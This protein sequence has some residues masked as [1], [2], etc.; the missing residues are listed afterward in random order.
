M[1]RELLREMGLDH[2]RYGTSMWNPL[3]DWIRRGQSVFALVNFVTDRR[4]TQ[5]FVDFTAMVTHPSVI[6]PV[7]DYLIIAT[8]DATLVNFGNAPVQSARM[9]RLGRG[10]GADRL[11]EFSLRHV[12]RE[13]GPHDLRLYTSCVNALGFKTRSTGG[14]TS[15]EVVFD[16]G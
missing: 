5:T 11:R 6:R 12:G 3:G 16:L 7:L 9:D 4:P 13:L 1:V 14:D 8:G 2:A 15:Q 10:K